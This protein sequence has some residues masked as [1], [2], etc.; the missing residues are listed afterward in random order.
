VK[1][2]VLKQL[3]ERLLHCSNAFWVP[4]GD[5]WRLVVNYKHGN[6]FNVAHMCRFESLRMLQRY[7]FKN[8]SAVKADMADA[9]Y[10][11]PLH[12]SAVQYFCF[13]FTG[14]YY[15]GAAHN[16]LKISAKTLSLASPQ[17]NASPQINEGSW[18]LLQQRRSNRHPSLGA[19]FRSH[20]SRWVYTVK[21]QA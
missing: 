6:K 8:A 11:V 10:Q 2:G 20:K 4:K 12:P 19:C 15:P 7:E 5:S 18:Q 17:T 1:L 3:Y 9:F 13:E 16:P 21:N 14:C